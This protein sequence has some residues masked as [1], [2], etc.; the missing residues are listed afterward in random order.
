M[1]SSAIVCS[2]NKYKNIDSIDNNRQVTISSCFEDKEYD[3]Q[4]AGYTPFYKVLFIHLM[5]EGKWKQLKREVKAYKALRSASESS[6]FFEIVLS[7]IT[8]LLFPD[9]FRY[10][11]NSIYK[12]KIYGRPFPKSMYQNEHNKMLYRLDNKKDPRQ[13]IYEG[14]NCGIRELLHYEDRN[15]MAHSIEARTPFLDYELAEFVFSVPLE[16]KIVNGRTK[17]IFKRRSKGSIA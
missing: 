15:S 4:L 7:T 5:K 9:W 10:M 13:Y 14:M 8:T 11:L 6:S 2:V 16:Q 17:N 3:E 12:D 1:D